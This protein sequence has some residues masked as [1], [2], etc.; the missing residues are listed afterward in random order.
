VSWLKDVAVVDTKQAHKHLEYKAGGFVE[1]EPTVHLDIKYGTKTL[2]GG[3]KQN[4]LE[5]FLVIGT[6][7]R[8]FFGND[9]VSAGSAAYALGAQAWRGMMDEIGMVDGDY[10][11][12]NVCVFTDFTAGSLALDIADPAKIDCSRE[13]KT[14]VDRE[15]WEFP[16]Q[17][18]SGSGFWHNKLK[19][20]CH[21]LCNA[22]KASV[23]LPNWEN[24]KFP[25][26]G[27]K[28]LEAYFG[29]GNVAIRFDNEY[30]TTTKGL[31][32]ASEA[33]THMYNVKK[34][35]DRAVR[36]FKFERSMLQAHVTQASDKYLNKKGNQLMDLARAYPFP[37]GIGICTAKDVT[38][39]L[40]FK[41]GAFSQVTG[42]KVAFEF[43]GTR[44][45]DLGL[46]KFEVDIGNLR[47]LSKAWR[48]KYEMSNGQRSS[49]TIGVNAGFNYEIL[50]GKLD[51]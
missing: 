45:S 19:S 51:V 24:A 32:A 3:E 15:K 23:D 36:N 46:A 22:F 9:P 26:L 48:E 18:T 33:L 41:V 16:T 20:K 29:P 13:E 4:H 28:T 38:A 10:V 5:F 42:K 11:T 2:D 44:D 25:M 37:V 7:F 43:K 40:G 21:Q 8:K 39:G 1:I 47:G 35:A 30:W 6:E 49:H 14:Y 31:D 27:R 34:N 17:I 12:K 50:L